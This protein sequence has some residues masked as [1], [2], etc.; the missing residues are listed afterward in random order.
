MNSNIARKTATNV[1]KN[2]TTIKTGISS[3]LDFP[4]N[5]INNISITFCMEKIILPNTIEANIGPSTKK[6]KGF[7]E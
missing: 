1:Q 6:T 7:Q 4:K 3:G 2:I 5:L